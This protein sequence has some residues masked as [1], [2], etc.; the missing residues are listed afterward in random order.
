MNQKLNWTFRPIALLFVAFFISNDIAA[1]ID[2]IPITIRERID[3]VITFDLETKEEN[4]VIVKVDEYNFF[5]VDTITV[6]DTETFEETVTVVRNH[7]PV[8]EYV[9]MWLNE[10]KLLKNIANKKYYG[11]DTLTVFDSNTY[12]E[13]YS[14]YKRTDPCYYITWGNYGLQEISNQSVSGMERKIKYPIQINYDGIKDGCNKA[15]KYSMNVIVTAP[16][17]N[18]ISFNLTESDEMIPEDKIKPYIKKGA[19][20]FI[21]HIKIND[22]HKLNDVYALKVI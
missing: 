10:D 13:F 15:G 20:I 1:S 8:R 21:H 12:E 17:M 5:T 6:F 18:A 14:V 3:T 16:G 4:Q 2:T 7:I 19:R 11:T 9:E 22:E